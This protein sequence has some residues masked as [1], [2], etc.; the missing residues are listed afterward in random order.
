MSTLVSSMR[1]LSKALWVTQCSVVPAASAVAC[2]NIGFS[3]VRAPCAAWV[4]LP[5]RA[6]AGVYS[7]CS[8]GGLRPLHQQRAGSQS[9]GRPAS[10]LPDVPG[11]FHVLLWTHPV[12]CGPSWPTRR[13]CVLI[14][15]A[16]AGGAGF[17]ELA[18]YIFGG[19]AGSEKMEMTTPGVCTLSCSHLHTQGFASLAR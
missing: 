9:G 8:P 3:S 2:S 5:G 12:W 19:N 4:W 13:C 10:S 15:A 1:A 14:A 18:S 11:T 6:A 7:H 16:P 17:S